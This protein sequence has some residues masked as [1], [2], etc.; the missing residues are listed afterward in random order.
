MYPAVTNVKPLSDYQL[1]I[2]FDNSDPINGFQLV[3]VE[4]MSVAKNHLQGFMS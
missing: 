2:T 4:K 1:L 3:V